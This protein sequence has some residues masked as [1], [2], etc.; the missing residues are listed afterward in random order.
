MYLKVKEKLILQVERLHRL[1]QLVYLLTD[2][3]S[4]CTLDPNIFE[5]YEM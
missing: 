4:I 3:P 5:S 2:T 1:I